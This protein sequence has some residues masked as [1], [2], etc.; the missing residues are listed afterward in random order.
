MKRPLETRE[1]V[2]NMQD[3]K[4]EFKYRP[5]PDL[6]RTVLH[7]GQKKLFISELDFLTDYSDDG[8]T[9]VYVGAAPGTHLIYLSDLFPT[10]KFIL[11]D[12]R[13]FDPGLYS[14]PQFELRQMF[15]TDSECMRFFDLNKSNVLLIS[16]IRTGNMETETEDDIELIV[17]NNMKEQEQWYRLCQ[18]K[19]ALFKFRLPYY[20]SNNPVLKDDKMTFPYLDGIVRIQAFPRKGSAE[21][22]LIPNGKMTNWNI[23]EIEDRFMTHNLYRAAFYE[24]EPIV[25]CDHCYDCTQEIYMWKK[26]IERFG[27]DNTVQELIDTLNSTLSGGKFNNLTYPIKN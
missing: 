16:D 15:F 1:L 3:V 11:Y 10:L 18:P 22:R 27:V 19:K 13:D 4:P 20:F 6:K 9:V 24:H 21:G 12:G 25:G 17:A 8:D 14:H 5:L 7:W 2:L 26:Y 23:K